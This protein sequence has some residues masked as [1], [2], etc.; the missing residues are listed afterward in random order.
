[1]KSYQTIEFE[2]K[3]G[4]G[5]LSLNRPEVRNAIS[6][7]MIAELLDIV[8]D[9]EKDNELRVLILTGKGKA[10]MVAHPRVIFAKS[11]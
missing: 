7:E 3:E 1:M 5:Y 4:I 6:E 11:S 10:F 8:Q 9:I 2:A